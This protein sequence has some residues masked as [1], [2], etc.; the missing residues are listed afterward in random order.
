MLTSLLPPAACASCRLCC[1]FLPASVWETP[2]LEPAC[3]ERLRSQGIALKERPEGGET[4]ALDFSQKCPQEAAECPL[5]DSAAG[6]RLPRSER[7][8]E[9]RLW[10]LRLMHD[11]AGN[12]VLAYYHSCPGLGWTTHE[13][14]LRLAESLRPLLWERSKEF[15]A[16]V[17]PMHENY[18]ILFVLN[19]SASPPQIS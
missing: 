14:L 9:C 19:E 1:N 8:I 15:P 17:R 16:F 10:P 5:L 12:I 11:E 6:C 4:I 7:P 3:A 2:A 13:E 18:T